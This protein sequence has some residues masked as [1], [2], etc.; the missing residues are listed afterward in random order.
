MVFDG[1]FGSVP[2]EGAFRVVPV[3][4]FSAREGYQRAAHDPIG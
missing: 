2:A 1:I 3:H 4:M